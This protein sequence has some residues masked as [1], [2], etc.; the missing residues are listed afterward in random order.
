MPTFD[1][2][3]RTELLS[4]KLWLY[5]IAT[6]YGAWLICADIVERSRMRWIARQFHLSFTDKSLPDGFPIDLIKTHGTGI[7]TI[8]RTDINNT[9]AGE[10]GESLLLVARLSLKTGDSWKNFTVIAR[11]SQSVRT[12][13]FS[14]N[15]IGPDQLEIPHALRKQ[16]YIESSRW[17]AIVVPK[18]KLSSSHIEQ[19]WLL[20]E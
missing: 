7:T 12:S 13:P 19:A 4:L 17:R 20:L 3:Y 10:R 16:R 9:V 18:R 6:I 14:L 11:R 8:K 5:S 2:F 1:D 15:G